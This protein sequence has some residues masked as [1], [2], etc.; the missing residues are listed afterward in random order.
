MITSPLEQ[1]LPQCM[2]I[3]DNDEYVVDDGFPEGLFENPWV[4][5]SSLWAYLTTP[6]KVLYTRTLTINHPLCRCPKLDDEISQ[7]SAFEVVIKESMAL[8][9]KLER[10]KFLDRDISI[11]AKNYISWCQNQDGTYTSKPLKINHIVQVTRGVQEEA[12]AFFSEGK[13][14]KINEVMWEAD[15]PF[16]QV[17]ESSSINGSKTL[18]YNPNVVAESL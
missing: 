13:R 4:F 1:P 14:A 15:I 8:F 9:S 12:L 11:L 3:P 6:S 2:P 10:S 5:I 17:Y 16:S 18:V 7:I